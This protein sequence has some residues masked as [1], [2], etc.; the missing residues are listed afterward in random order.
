[1]TLEKIATR[2]KEI[3]EVFASFYESLYS[4]ARAT[5]MATQEV[6]TQSLEPVSIEELDRALKQVKCGRAHDGAGVAAEMLKYGGEHLRKAVLDLFNEVLKPQNE[7]PDS[8]RHT[9]LLVLFKKGDPALPKNYRPIATLPVLYK[10]FSRMLCNRIQ[11]TISRN[12][13][14]QAIRLGSI[15]CTIP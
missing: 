2:K 4:S 11:D 7:V 5:P 1:M 3:S 15:P 13:S 12:Q 9:K 6:G 8:W 10:A 14:P